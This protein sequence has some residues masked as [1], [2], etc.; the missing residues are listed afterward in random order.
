MVVLTTFYKSGYKVRK[1]FILAAISMDFPMVAIEATFCIAVLVWMDS[2]QLEH[3][4]I[5]LPFLI[6]GIIC[7]GV[8]VP[9]VHRISAKRFEKVDL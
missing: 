5:Q 7:Y 1:S 3:L 4:L 9:L 6:V 8:L 2:Y